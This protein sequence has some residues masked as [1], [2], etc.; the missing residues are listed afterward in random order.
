MDLAILQYASI[1]LEL[2]ISIMGIILFFE[3]KKYGIGIFTTFGIYVFYDLVR[4]IGFE[5]NVNAMYF[6]FFIA[7]LSIFLSII[8]LISVFEMFFKK[9]KNWRKK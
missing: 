7:T 8:S 6:L 4:E 5:T 9:N 2:V 1:L 3:K